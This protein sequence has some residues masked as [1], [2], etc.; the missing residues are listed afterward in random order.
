MKSTRITAILILSLG[1]VFTGILA[2]CGGSNASIQPVISH[3]DGLNIPSATDDG[4]DNQQTGENT[5]GDN[6]DIPAKGVSFKWEEGDASSGISRSCID[7]DKNYPDVERARA[8]VGGVVVEACTPDIY[9]G[10]AGKCT[11]VEDKE[12]TNTIYYYSNYTAA[13]A[14][15]VCG[16]LKGTWVSAE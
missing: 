1:L 3:D 10:Y 15:G 9:A 6:V 16:A 13:I 12:F 14:Q 4:T 7:Y 2:G 8:S 5:T 11:F